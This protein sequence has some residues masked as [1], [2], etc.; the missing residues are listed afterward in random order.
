MKAEKKACRLLTGRCSNMF[1]RAGEIAACVT[2]FP[3]AVLLSY[4]VQVVSEDLNQQRIN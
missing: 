4:P 2:I 1:K 3:A